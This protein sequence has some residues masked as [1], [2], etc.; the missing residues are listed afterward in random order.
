MHRAHWALHC[1]QGAG[2]DR[3]AMCMQVRT[4]TTDVALVERV[5]TR[6]TVPRPSTP[7]GLL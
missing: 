1:S 6:P 5:G 3:P 4:A 2:K 7:E